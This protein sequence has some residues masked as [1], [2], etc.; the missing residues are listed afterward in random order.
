M[1]VKLITL[2][3]RAGRGWRFD[4]SLSTTDD[5]E[6]VQRLEAAHMRTFAPPE[7]ASTE[8][9]PLWSQRY[10]TDEKSWVFILRGR[11]GEF[12]KAG[13]H[14]FV[15]A[16][17]GV[18]GRDLW[19]ACVPAIGADGLLTPKSLV[20]RSGSRRRVIDPVDSD[21]AEVMAGLVGGTG[22]VKSA[23][24]PVAM[25]PLI[26]ALLRMLPDEAARSVIWNTCA[27][28][29]QAGPVSV[30]GTWPGDPAQALGLAYRRIEA[31][32]RTA[33]PV[34]E[35]TVRVIDWVVTAARSEDYPLL[36]YRGDVSNVLRQ[37]APQRP[38]LVSEVPGILAL[39]IPTELD[40]LARHPD[41]LRA[42][43]EKHPDVATALLRRLNHRALWSVVYGTTLTASDG[44]AWAT[45]LGL[46]LPGQEHSRQDE[47][48]VKR[49]YQFLE[50]KDLLALFNGL[51]RVGMPWHDPDHRRRMRPLFRAAGFDATVHPQF[52]PL[53]PK[54]YADQLAAGR[55]DALL[56]ALE[57]DQAPESLLEAVLDQFNG[58]SYLPPPSAA[59]VIVLAMVLNEEIW[60]E[61]GRLSRWVRL[62]APDRQA[63]SWL[64]VFVD[65][66]S[67][68]LAAAVTS[69]RMPP[70]NAQHSRQALGDE[71]RGFVHS[72]TKRYPHDLVAALCELGYG[73]PRGDLGRSARPAQQDWR[74]APQ[75]GPL[76]SPEQNIIPAPHSPAPRP[77]SGVDPQGADALWLAHQEALRLGSSETGVEIRSENSRFL[78]RIRNRMRRVSRADEGSPAPA[79]TDG[80][81]L[82]GFL[83][84]TSPLHDD[85]YDQETTDLDER[86]G[87]PMTDPARWGYYPPHLLPAQRTPLQ[88]AVRAALWTV[89]IVI[90]GIALLLLGSVL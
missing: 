82:L 1:T 54:E 80:I 18:T 88:K 4:P 42:Y 40:R 49:M 78:T 8:G 12:G 25:A 31:A 62:C 81:E 75:R 46:P 35:E 22:V 61:A 66:C 51:I 73:W 3:D 83:G 65:Q 5:G 41:V 36:R 59:E 57:S 28:D 90:I 10:W 77:A 60:Q 19:Q 74:S 67:G 86:S 29:A 26:G 15:V 37:A 39:S 85:V 6:L 84:E 32:S 71:V 52:F 53:G 79:D 89:G 64:E 68:Q 38:P 43:V 17:E 34:S 23:L 72:T 20:S 11:G 58:A 9:I 50:P 27:L 7:V 14:Q 33:G 48:L 69:G 63:L 2:S 87:Q 44:P 55:T 76:P 30:T 13:T 16:S 56:E 21:A 47:D 70:V 24:D 45:R